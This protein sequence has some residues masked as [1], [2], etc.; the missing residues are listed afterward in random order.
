MTRKK[1]ATFVAVL[2]M[3]MLFLTVVMWMFVIIGA[4]P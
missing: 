4:E 2:L 1:D 3:A